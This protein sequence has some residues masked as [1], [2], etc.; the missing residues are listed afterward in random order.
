MSNAVILVTNNVRHFLLGHVKKIEIF[1]SNLNE[2]ANYG[3][4]N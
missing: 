3:K 1:E 2:N 4:G